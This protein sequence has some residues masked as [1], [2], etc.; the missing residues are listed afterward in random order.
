MPDAT[1]QSL[2]HKEVATLREIIKALREE[3]DELKQINQVLKLKVDAMARK[4]FGKSSEKLDPAQLQLVLEAL[5]NQPPIERQ[6]PDASASEVSD[7]EI[8]ASGKNP[9]KKRSLDEL[10][11]HLP[12]VEIIIDPDEVK[13]EPAAWTCIG[14]EV[15]KLIDIIPSKFRC[16][17]IIRRKYV[18]NDERH[19]PPI[20]A[21]LHTLQDRCIATPR[22]LAHTITQRFELHL[23]FYR[24][25]QQYARLGLPISRQTLCGWTGMVSDACV[26][27]IEKIKRDVFQG[28]YVQVDALRGAQ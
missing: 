11:E 24:I 1:H 13:A 3:I 5:E 25:E 19:L 6:N 15:T 7:S 23:P 2:L 9:R 26:L 28:G 8:E 18:R 21:P 4:L 20:I 17:H 16:E 12:V 14:E 10:I 27:I 22:T